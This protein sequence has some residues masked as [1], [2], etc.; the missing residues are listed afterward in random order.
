MAFT[1]GRGCHSHKGWSS[2]RASYVL[3]ELGSFLSSLS[4]FFVRFTTLCGK[5]RVPHVRY[6]LQMRVAVCLEMMSNLQL[7]L[8]RR[9]ILSIV[10][11]TACLVGLHLR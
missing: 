7:V 9:S 2:A 8:E 5:Y 10:F 1:V 3:L 11:I 4:P 6:A